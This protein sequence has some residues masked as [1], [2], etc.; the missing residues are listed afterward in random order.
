MSKYAAERT[1]GKKTAS[2]LKNYVAMNRRPLS[3]DMRF[4]K[5]SRVMEHSG[6]S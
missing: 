4:S 1:S 6:C 3:P 5:I 2:Q